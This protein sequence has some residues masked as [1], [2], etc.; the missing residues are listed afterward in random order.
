MVTL[1]SIQELITGIGSEGFRVRS[2][3]SKGLLGTVNK[4]M[5]HHEGK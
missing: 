1:P 4:E 2:P 3:T 5:E